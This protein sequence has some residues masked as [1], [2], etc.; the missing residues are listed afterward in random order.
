MPKNAPTA[1]AQVVAAAVDDRR[2]AEGGD[3][4]DKPTLLQRAYLPVIRWTLRFPAITPGL[5]QTY[6]TTA[7]ALVT[8]TAGNA[9]LSAVDSSNGTGRLSNGAFSLVAPI[10]LRATNAANPNTA[11]AALTGVPIPLLAWNSW[12]SN[13][14]VT[15]WLHQAIGANEPLLVG[16]YGKLITFTL[17]TTTP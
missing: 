13:D 2:A 4:L 1:E 14:A 9:M 8:S 12:I 17:S 6:E 7:S 10:Q 16:P 15:I 3:E 11:Y 5:Q